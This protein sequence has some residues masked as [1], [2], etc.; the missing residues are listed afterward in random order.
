MILDKGPWNKYID[1]T[2]E[3]HR[4]IY[5]T[6]MFDLAKQYGTPLFVLFED[7]IVNNY[8]KYRHALEKEYKDHLI[9]YAVKANTSYCVLNLLSKL[10][11]GADV[12][13]EYELQ[14][15]LNAGIPVEKIRVNGNCKN[16]SYLEECIK[17]GI[18]I[19]V[20]PEEELTIINAIAFELGIAAKINIRFAG[21]PVK[22]ITSRAITTSS[23]WSKFGIDIKRANSVFRK[24]LE[25][26]ML[27]PNGLMVHLGSQITDIST[28]YTVLEILIDLSRDAQRIG[29]DINEIDLGGGLGIPYF[30][31][32]HWNAIKKKIKNTRKEN[33]TWADEFIGYEYNAESDDMEWIGEEL[34]SAYAPDTFIQKLFTEK[35]SA[36]KTF[37][38]KLEEIGSPRF[39][40]EPG[41]SII[42]NAGVT[43]AKIG[44]VSNTPRGENIVH[45]DAGVNS[46]TFGTAVPEQLHRT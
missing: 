19:N 25:L 37:K 10:G 33:Y 28:Y 6:D 29:F 44:H 43:I 31:P 16:E 38:E 5:G 26:D 15:A 21:F 20:D 14:L 45:V 22:H 18:L 41:R 35:Y 39:V 34:S 4:K 42:G 46:H 7:I 13:S 23:D 27:I 2:E 36:N 1:E 11:S 12:A 17:K 30:E 3:S 8:E 24:V 9:C 32:E 40:I